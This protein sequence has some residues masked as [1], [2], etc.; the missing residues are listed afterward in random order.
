[1]NC[2]ASAGKARAEQEGKALLALN[3]AMFHF[4]LTDNDASHSGIVQEICSAQIDLFV[5]KIRCN[6]GMS[7]PSRMDHGHE[8]HCDSATVSLSI[9]R[10]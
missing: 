6:V 2:G 7:I 8:A 10:S 4:E 9:C 5:Q 1:M 3:R